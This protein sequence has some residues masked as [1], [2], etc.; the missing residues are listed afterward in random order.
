MQLH[1]STTKRRQLERF[2]FR[3][4]AS[5]SGSKGKHQR[6]LGSHLGGFLE[7]IGN[8]IVKGSTFT[9]RDTVNA[10][11][12][13]IVNEAFA[14]KFFPNE[15]PI[16]KHFGRTDLKFSGTYASVVSPRTRGSRRT[17]CGTRSAPFASWPELRCFTSTSPRLHWA[18]R[19][20]ITCTT[21]QYE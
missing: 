2:I 9:D 20:L 11:K 16:G 13:A 17:I 3:R 5:G 15:D 18:R 21:P 8:P 12:V 4:R 1:G 7:T 19:A 14:R 10:P 6:R